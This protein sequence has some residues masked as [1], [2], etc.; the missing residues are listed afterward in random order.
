VVLWAWCAGSPRVPDDD[1]EEHSEDLEAE[2]RNHLPAVNVRQTQ[3]RQ[4][5]FSAFFATALCK[6]GPPDMPA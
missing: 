4:R 5:L 2:F 3:V 6:S 1:E